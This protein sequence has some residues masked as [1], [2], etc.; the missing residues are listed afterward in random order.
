L[1]H[2]KI[3]LTIGRVAI[4]RDPTVAPIAGPDCEVVT[5]AMRDLK[6][7]ERHDGVGGFCASGLIDNT[8][9]AAPR[10]PC[11]SPSRKAACCGRLDELWREQNARWPCDASSTGIV[12]AASAGRRHRMK[13]GFDA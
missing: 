13:V 4:L 1:P 12:D 3:A 10:R 7:G 8:A 2:I 9:T 6:D 11:P 5:V